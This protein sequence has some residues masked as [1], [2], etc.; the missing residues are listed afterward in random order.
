M[1]DP[2]ISHTIKAKNKHL[3]V[4]YSMYEGR[5]CLGSPIIVMQRGKIL[6]EEGKLKDEPAQGK[7]IPGKIN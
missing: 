3:K 2:G 6:L 7:Y 5:E 1:F 4:D